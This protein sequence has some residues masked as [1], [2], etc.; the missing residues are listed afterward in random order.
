MKEC[1]D[2]FDRDADGKIEAK[3][4]GEV[5]RSLGQILIEKDVV[6]LRKEVVGDLVAF[7]KFKELASRKPRQP[8][9]QS[10]ALMQAFEVFDKIGT[11]QVDMSELQHIVTSMGEKLS[12]QEFQDI[13]KAAGLAPSGSVEYRQ[14]V[15][16]VIKA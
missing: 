7:D 3:Q 13:C 4:L 1:F 8:E 5:L 14:V 9:K 10:K 6:E 2:L 16:K 12:A 15:D 11:G